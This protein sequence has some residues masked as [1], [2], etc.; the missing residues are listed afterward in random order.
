MIQ[1]YLGNILGSSLR[2]CIRRLEHLKLPLQK[3]SEIWRR[4]DMW[5]LCPT[6]SNRNSLVSIPFCINSAP[7]EGSTS[8]VIRDEEGHIASGFR[9]THTLILFIVSLWADIGKLNDPTMEVCLST[10]STVPVY[11]LNELVPRFLSQAPWRSH[12]CMSDVWG[13]T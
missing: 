9:R 1:M 13:N 8:R 11:L 4:H 10:S 3:S 6:W 12:F 7:F 2:Q 5:K